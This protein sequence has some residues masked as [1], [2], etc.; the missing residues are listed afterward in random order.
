MK[1]IIVIIFSILSTLSYCQVRE[2]FQTKQIVESKK[3][4]NFLFVKDKKGKLIPYGTGFFVAKQID[5]LWQKI[6][7]VTSKHVLKDSVGNY[8]K[9]IIIRYNLKIGKFD[10][11]QINLI[12][13]GSKANVFFHP[14]STVDLAL[15]PL[16]GDFEKIDFS[17]LNANNMLN[18]SEFLKN[19]IA[20]GTEV[21]F[22]GLFTSYI[23]Q[24]KNFP[25]SRFGKI[26]LVPEEKIDFVDAKR[27]LI[28]L[29]TT[30]YGGNSGSPVFVSYSFGNYT[31]R[32]LIGV[33]TGSFEQFSEVGVLSNSIHISKENSGISAITPCKY[34]IELLDSIK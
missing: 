8:L 34:L 9:S 22:S 7:L 1:L 20:E 11:S 21:F 4:V 32:K 25:I 31:I 18:S 26:A 24:G 29:E 28:L 15:I 10:L 33:M 3:V 5:S 13:E 23:G 14:D 6:Y 16:A 17:S 12:T 27:D 19:G 30:A 2:N